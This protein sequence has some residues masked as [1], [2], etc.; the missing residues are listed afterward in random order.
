VS[1]PASSV[2]LFI[3]ASGFLFFLFGLLSILFRVIQ[4]F[5]LGDPPLEM[6]VLDQRFLYLQ[7]IPSLFAAI[8]FLSGATALYLRQA[9]Q[10]G[11]LGLVVYFIAF[12][13]LVI[14]TGAM[15]TYAFTA[16]ALAR[17][18]PYLLSSSTS[19]IIK[20]VM[21][22]M[23][24]GQLGWLLLL[25][26]SLKGR[27]VPRWALVVAILSIVLVVIATPYVQTQVHRLLYNVL[28]GIG[29]LAVGYVLWHG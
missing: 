12:T 7:G 13:G 11:R 8:F 26:V 22:S 19:A 1:K 16:P 6:L 10:T 2:D 3:R 20:A 27:G 18:A 21:G 28:L 17:G 5:V 24:V 9:K 15:W 29:P 14:S 4:F 23:V 25:V